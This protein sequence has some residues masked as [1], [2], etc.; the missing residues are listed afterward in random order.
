MDHISPGGE[1]VSEPRDVVASEM[2]PSRMPVWSHLEALR[3]TLFRCLLI[4]LVG[5]SITYF[6]SERVLYFLERPLFAVLPK[7]QAFLYFTGVADKFFIY[8]KVSIYSAIALCSPLL[9]YEIWKFVAP[10]LYRNEKRFFGPFLLFGTGAFFT[11]MTFAYTVVI[12]TG[13]KFLLEFG[14]DRERPLITMNDYFSLTLQL[15]LAMGAVFELPVVMMLLAK[16]GIIQSHTLTKIR[17]QAYIA[18][19]ILAAVVTPTPDAFTMVLVLVPLCLLYE[20]SVVLV[21]WIAPSETT[22]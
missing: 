16:F 8:L 7:E 15:L 20:L 17:P 13:Y 22:A 18:L 12:P 3:A 11:G 1:T 2:D 6:Y 21:R 10:A 4:L 14:P 5:T 9:I 19:A